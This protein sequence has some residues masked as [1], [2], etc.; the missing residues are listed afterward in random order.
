SGPLGSPT[1]DSERTMVTSSTEH[2]TA[3]LISFGGI[4]GLEWAGER[5]SG[6]MQKYAAGRDIHF[7]II[8]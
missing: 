3:I 4:D 7:E 8:S 1:R 6:L 2:V 5:I